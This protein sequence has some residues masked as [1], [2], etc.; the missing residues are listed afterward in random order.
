MAIRRLFSSL[1]TLNTE[2]LNHFRSFLASHQVLTEDLDFYNTDWLHEHKGDSKLVLKPSSTRQVQ[3]ILKYCNDQR[4]GVV[5][6][7]GN[8]SLV[9]GSVPIN[10]EIILSMQNLNKI[11]NFDETQGIVWCESGVI[12]QNL[13]SYCNEKGW[14]VPLDLGAK[15][16]CLI[17]GNISTNAGGVR[18]I[19]YGSLNGNVL[20]LEVILPNGEILSDLKALR[21][22]NTGLNL[23]QIFIGSEG[24]LGVITR[25]ALLLAPKPASVQTSFLSVRSYD[26]VVK[27]LGLAKDHLGEIMSAYEFIDRETFQIILKH[28]PRTLNPFDTNFDFY[29]LVE[30][31]GSNQQHDSEK[32]E[33]FLQ[34]AYDKGIVLDGSIAQNQSQADNFWRIRENGAVA[35]R[36]EAKDIFKFDFSMRIPEMYEFVLACKER[37]GSLGRVMG[38]GHVGDGN[39][40]MTVITENGK[41]VEKIL[42]PYLYEEVCRRKGSISAEHGIGLFK[43]GLIGYSKDQA[44]IEYMV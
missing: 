42:Y 7:S 39:L 29:V 6:Q 31:S 15:G 32:M 19:R 5:T 9:A 4:L 8:T 38:Y 26:D 27:L 17:G 23:K 20:G 41:E 1:S 18:F 3:E 28:T 40:H 37:V 14:I 43:Q 36:K 12:I 33:S 24:L 44:T 21:K 22:D 10:S 11:E 35:T 2:H 34:A 30:T 25:V 13:N 16:S